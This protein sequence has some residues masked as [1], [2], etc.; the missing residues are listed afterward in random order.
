M[1]RIAKNFSKYSGS[2]ALWGASWHTVFLQK[3]LGYNLDVDFYIDSNEEKAGQMFFGKPVISPAM[4]QKHKVDE[5]VISSQA[6]EKEIYQQLLRMKF[7]RKK[8]W[9]IYGQ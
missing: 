5:I 6:F 9:C 4:I 3:V 2:L 7:P 1:G 8:I